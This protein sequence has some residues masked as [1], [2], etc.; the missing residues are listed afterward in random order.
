MRCR[1]L[2]GGN[3]LIEELNYMAKKSGWKG[4]GAFTR[5]DT[6]SGSKCMSSERFKLASGEKMSSKQV[7]SHQ[8]GKHYARTN[9]ENAIGA[10]KKGFTGGIPG[11]APHPI[12]K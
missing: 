10:N 8:P 3:G 4:S 7:V 11:P 6:L 12:K 1:Y 9:A 2:R 5:A